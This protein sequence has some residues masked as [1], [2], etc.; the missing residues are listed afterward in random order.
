MVS[1]ITENG[2]WEGALPEGRSIIELPATHVI[3]DAKQMDE[4]IKQLHD[5]KKV[6]QQT[7]TVFASVNKLDP[8]LFNGGSLNWGGLVMKLQKAKDLGPEF[9][10]LNTLVQQ[11]SKKYGVL[12]IKQS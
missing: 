10:E 12:I 5:A 4:M 2:K 6:I 8:N 3:V 9:A 1:R 11:Y 7:A